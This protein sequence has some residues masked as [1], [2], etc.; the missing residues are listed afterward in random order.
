MR[1][2]FGLAFLDIQASQ[3]VAIIQQVSEWPNGAH[4]VTLSSGVEIELV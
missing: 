3:S 4:I 2:Y 1:K